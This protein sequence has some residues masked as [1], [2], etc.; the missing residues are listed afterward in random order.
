MIRHFSAFRLAPFTFVIL[1]SPLACKG[2]DPTIPSNASASSSTVVYDITRYG[3]V[4][5]GTTLNTL[6][7]QSAIDKAAVTGGGLVSIPQ[8]EFLSGAL[9]L[10]P[11]VNLRL[12]KDAV[13]KGATD[14]ANY[15]E[16]RIR[17]EGH[18]EEHYTPALVNAVGCDGLQITGEGTL[19]GNGL[20]V[21]KEFWRLHDAAPDKKN[22]KNLSIPRAQLCI[23]N[24]SKNVRVDGVTFKDSQ[25]WNLHLYNCRNV[26]VRNARFQVPDDYKRAPS[27]DGIDVDSSQ[28]VQIKSCYFSVT[29]DSICMKG[30]KGPNALDDKDSPP[31]EH[32]RVSDCTFKRGDAAVTCGSEATIVRDLVVE[33]C[34]IIGAMNVLNLKLRSDTP[35]QYEDIHCRGLTLDNAGG[36]LIKIAPWTQYTDLNGQPPPQST[37]RNITFSDVK[38]RYGKFGIIQGNRGQT[39]ISEISF[40]NIDV[41]LKDALLKAGSDVKNLKFENVMLNGKPVTTSP[42]SP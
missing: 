15:P 27:S 16:G 25:Y 41:T 7:I 20:P 34:H 8:G 11:G 6:A 1:L 24:N 28:D 21:W 4:G 3:A 30:S 40:Q 18:F 13:L 36:T 22:F 39:E 32:V 38:G 5:D 23:I 29:D 2:S 42:P 14:M 10:K 26:T 19:D 17:I 12:E 31:V 37:V 35:Q 33:N 9:F